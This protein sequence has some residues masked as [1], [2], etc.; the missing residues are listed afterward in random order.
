M[1]ETGLDFSFYIV[2]V[3][4]LRRLNYINVEASLEA[5]FWVKPFISKTFFNLTQFLITNRHHLPRL[6]LLGLV[7][8]SAEQCIVTHLISVYNLLDLDNSKFTVIASRMNAPV[9]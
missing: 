3:F 5:P 1:F 8:R 4:H 2:T 9:V 7:L 6:P